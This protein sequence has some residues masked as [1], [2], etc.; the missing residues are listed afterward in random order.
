M[1]INSKIVAIAIDKD[2]NMYDE[3]DITPSTNKLPC[4]H[5]GSYNITVPETNLE[6]QELIPILT[7]RKW[8]RKCGKTF[9]TCEIWEFDIQPTNNQ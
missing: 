3:G 7:R 8:C 5:C 4:P 1:G 2:D 9:R 6:G